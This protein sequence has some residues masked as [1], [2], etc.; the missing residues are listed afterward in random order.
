[1]STT[2]I[3]KLELQNFR[4]FRELS[5]TF[6]PELTVLVAP[7]GGGKT[8]ILDALAAA[9]HKFVAA[10]TTSKRDGRLGYDDVRRVIGP[11][12]TMELVL[13]THLIAKGIIS[14][15]LVEWTRRITGI[16]HEAVQRASRAKKLFGIAS[17]LHH[18]VIEYSER[19]RPD[20]PTLPVFGYY[21]TGRLWNLQQ[22]KERAPLSRFSGYTD[23]LSSASNYWFFSDWFGR[24][25][26]EAQSEIDS[27]Y[28]SPHNPHERLAAVRNAVSL[29]LEPTGWKRLEWR[30]AE[31][32]LIAV[33]PQDGELPVRSLSDGIRNMIGMVGDLAHR[34]VRLNPQFGADA[35]KMSPGIVL[36]DEVDM[37]LHPEWQQLVVGQLRK[38]FPRI[39]FIVTTHSPQ[40]LSTVDKQSIR[41]VRM[42]DY[43]AT[44]EVPKF[45]TRGVESADVLTFIM[46]VHPVPQVEEARLLSEYRAL[47]ED[48]KADTPEALEM[49]QRLIAHFG[50]QHPIMIDCDRLIR[51]QNFKRGRL[52]AKQEG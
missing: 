15:R 29:L 47:I 25:A 10:L 8:A 34:C 33:H 21:S 18:H 32:V 38:A 22:R 17:S 46:G 30:F 39:Q 51:F 12:R 52:A 40:V 1:M 14:D 4:L 6:H 28:P 7:N 37:H 13:P 9:L 16:D 35:C 23:C 27:A 24:F 19:K 43:V 20:A 3:D 44:V 41:I 26:R 31:D 50:N 48:H 5:I 42:H 49:R 11:E 45:Q 2:R 36:I